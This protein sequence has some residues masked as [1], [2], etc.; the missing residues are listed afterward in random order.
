MKIA[1]NHDLMKLIYDYFTD[2]LEGYS[3]AEAEEA[4]IR[5]LRGLSY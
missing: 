5:A 1:E 2:I 4:I 3:K